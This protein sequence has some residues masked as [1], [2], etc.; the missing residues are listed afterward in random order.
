M[1]RRCPGTA[2]DSA[3]LRDTTTL[4]IALRTP[5]RGPSPSAWEALGAPQWPTAAQNAKILAASEMRPEVVAAGADGD[6][7]VGVLP[8]QGV[9]GVVIPRA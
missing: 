6:F 2:A 1:S 7:D 4:R 8:P 5:Q 9:V 3:R